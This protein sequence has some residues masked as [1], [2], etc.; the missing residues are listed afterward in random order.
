MGVAG[1]RT[2]GSL[3]APG[4]AEAYHFCGHIYTTD[5]CPHPTGLPRI[6]AKGLPL[7]AKDGRPVD[8]LGRYIDATGA[9]GGRGRRAARPT[10]TARRCPT[11]TARRSATSPRPSYG[12]KPHIDGA[13]YRCCGGHVRKLVDCC[14]YVQQPHQ[15]RQGADRLLLQRPQG[16]LRHVLR[17]EGQVLTAVVALA[18]RRRRGHRRVVAVR[19]LDGR[20]ARARAATPGGCGRRSI[21][22]ATFA[23]GALAGGVDH[24][25]RARAARRARSAPARRA[26]AA[27]DRARRRG[28]GEARG[29]RIVP[30]V[31]RQVP[32]SWRRVHARPARR[33]PLRRPAR[34][35]L[36]DL[37]PHA[38]PCG[39]WRGS[40]SRSATRRSGSLIGLGFGAGRALPGDRARAVAA[41]ATPARRDG[42]AP[43]HPA[44]RCGSLDAA[45]LAACAAALAAA[46][47]QAAVTV[48]AAGFADPSVDGPRFALHRPGGD[49]ELREPGGRQALPGN[50]PAVGGG[51]PAWI[52]G[53]DVVVAGRRRDPRARRGR[54]S[55]SRANWV[56]WRAGQDALRRA[57]RSATGLRGAHRWS[58]GNV[59][60]PALAG[61]LLVFDIDGRIESI[62]LD[63]RRSGR[64]CAAGAR[65]SCAARRCY[66]NRLAY[67][68]ARPTAA[69]RCMTGPLVPRSVAQ[70]PDALRHDAHRPAATPATSPAAFP[71]RATSTSRCGSARPRASTTR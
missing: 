47:A 4:E 3:V 41:A 53:S 17:H 15:R 66:G 5:S 29:A 61:N 44:R 9:A 45:A 55:R 49:G 35:R 1:A 65:R 42:R 67:V 56:A 37:H 39:R 32:E 57:A 8:D 71:P 23:A 51:R 48:T 31:R 38:S 40:A 2:V 10:P 69:S 50:H 26:V 60:R 36:H 64:C 33:R 13:W 12:F 16:L 62:D 63:D 46:P 14:G 7:K 20:D 24:V 6:D 19:V 18:A 21:A 58:T 68:I 30:Q 59:G 43:A 52:E 11:A 25:R 54:A 70:R 22:C 27:R 34:A 28:V